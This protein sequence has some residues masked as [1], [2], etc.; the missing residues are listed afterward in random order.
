MPIDYSHG[1]IRVGAP[2]VG[3]ITQNQFREQPEKLGRQE[4]RVKYKDVIEI[5]RGSQVEDKWK[6]SGSQVEDMWKS[7]EQTR[8]R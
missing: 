8:G 4:K 3:E 6:S 2:P 5:T 1:I 7:R